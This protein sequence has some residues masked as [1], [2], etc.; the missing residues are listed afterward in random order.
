MSTEIGGAL[1]VGAGVGWLDPHGA[2]KM[3]SGAEMQETVCCG[4]DT[5][6][7]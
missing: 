1:S 2:S 3:R 4:Q 6:V 7:C 5:G